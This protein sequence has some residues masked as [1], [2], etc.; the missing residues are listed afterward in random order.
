MQQGNTDRT[1]L[2][3]AGNLVSEVEHNTKAMPCVDDT[4]P[5]LQTIFNHHTNNVIT[6][7]E[8]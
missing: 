6:V 4:R 8:T 5:L 2:Q 7:S 1:G 3:M